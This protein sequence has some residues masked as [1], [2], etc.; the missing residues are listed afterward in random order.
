MGAEYGVISISATSE[1][2]IDLGA[3]AASTNGL[4]TSLLPYFPTPSLLYS[5][6]RKNYLFPLFPHAAVHMYVLCIYSLTRQAE[7]CEHQ[8]IPGPQ[9]PDPKT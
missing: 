4:S 9:E 6:Y 1:T 2:S 3:T 8:T 7:P 5:G